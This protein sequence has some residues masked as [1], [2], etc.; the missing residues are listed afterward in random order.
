MQVLQKP[1]DCFDSAQL[2]QI[3][4]ICQNYN[5]CYN[6]LVSVF[7]TW[8]QGHNS[9]IAQAELKIVFSSKTTWIKISELF[10]VYNSILTFISYRVETIVVFQN[11]ND[12][13]FMEVGVVFVA[14]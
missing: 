7:L 11:L 1:E 14:K 10:W 6:K 4:Q 3:F 2:R 8:F 13:S 12:R 9:I 5:F